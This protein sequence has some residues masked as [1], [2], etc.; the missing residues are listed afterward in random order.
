[1]K[2]IDGSEKD[3]YRPRVIPR[4]SPGQAEHLKIHTGAEW[5]IC[6][7]ENHVSP[8]VSMRHG[9]GSYNLKPNISIICCI[10][11][12]IYIIIKCSKTW[13]VHDLWY[14]AFT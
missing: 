14:S 13:H 10:Q 5:P 3:T 12:W 7:E 2:D 8:F 4:D 6:I 9:E 1:M 11:K